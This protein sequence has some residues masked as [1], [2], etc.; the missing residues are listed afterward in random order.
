MDDLFKFPIVM[1]DGDTE[2]RKESLAMNDEVEYIIGYA[3]CPYHD[4]LS[5][6]DRWMPTNDSRERAK[7]REFDACQV[8]FNQSG[9]YVVPWTRDKFKKKLKEFS[10]TMPLPKDVLS[11]ED[12]RQ[13][14]GLDGKDS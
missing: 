7:H 4:F 1:I 5:I 12:L 11:K 10:D 6:A 3:E 8:I 13:I 2:D 9:T 14:L